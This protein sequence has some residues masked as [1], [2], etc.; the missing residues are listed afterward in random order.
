M[1]GEVG[2]RGGAGIRLFA[3]PDADVM[4]IGSDN[5]QEACAKGPTPMRGC[6]ELVVGDIR[7]FARSFAA[8]VG[9]SRVAE[10]G[11]I[12]NARKGLAI[13]FRRSVEA[14]DERGAACILPIGARA[15]ADEPRGVDLIRGSIVARFVKTGA[16]HEELEA[17]DVAAGEDERV[18]AVNITGD[19]DRAALG[20]S[21]LNVSVGADEAAGCE[22]IPWTGVRGS[23]QAVV[24]SAFAAKGT[25]YLQAIG[26]GS[27]RDYVHHA[28]NGA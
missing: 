24:V 23:E 22:E 2:E 13:A 27:C 17:T 8:A 19:I 12:R 26:R 14:K 5:E 6:A 16:A 3:I 1:V 15:V 11:E 21:F 4:R 10:V 20:W 9:A 28:A 7:E 25:P 18:L